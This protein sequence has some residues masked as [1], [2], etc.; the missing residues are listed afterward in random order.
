[1]ILLVDDDAETRGFMATRLNA[2]GYRV[3][4]ASNGR[5]ALALLRNEMPCVMVVDLMMPV[6]DGAELRR[7]QQH[8]PAV[9]SVPF[10]LLSGSCDAE[11]IA[12]E[13]GIADVM[14][15]PVDTERLLGIIAGHC[16]CAR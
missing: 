15:K 10:I 5:E 9:S 14:A 8:S 13:L 6:M 7:H 1:M 16:G 3:C 2:A 12:R 11:R 4:T